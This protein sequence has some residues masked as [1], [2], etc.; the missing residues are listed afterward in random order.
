MMTVSRSRSSLLRH[1]G[2]GGRS[3]SVAC[4]RHLVVALL[5]PCVVAVVV[6]VSGCGA[7]DNGDEP[8]AR[9][10]RSPLSDKWICGLFSNDDLTNVLGFHTYDQDSRGSGSG[11]QF[12]S[13]CK[14][15]SNRQ[16]F[17]FLEITYGY[18]SD[19]AQLGLHGKYQF[20]EVPL[21]FSDTVEA[22]SYGSVEGD[23][24]VFVSGNLIYV[25][26][27]YPDGFRAVACLTFW[28]SDEPTDEQISGFL[29]VLE[30]AL[31]ELPRR[32]ARANAEAA[33][34]R[35]REESS[36]VPTGGETP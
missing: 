7:A 19:V 9:A 30:P 17:G 32:Q 25:V 5:V 1:R 34:E 33:E 21:V 14:A 27:A 13:T 24:W 3:K 16:P 36:A 10:A 29:V 20:G 8:A 2:S 11:D 31:A 35:A 28:E 4:L 12:Y 22:V 18:G 15:K 23:G 26:W 6:G